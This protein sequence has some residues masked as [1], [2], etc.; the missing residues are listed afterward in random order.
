MISRMM[1]V[2]SELGPSKI[3]G[4]DLLALLRIYFQRRFGP[5]RD[6]CAF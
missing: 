2:T 6:F 5:A 4:L 1:R 3:V